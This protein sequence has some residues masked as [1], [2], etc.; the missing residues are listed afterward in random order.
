MLN[1]KGLSVL[2]VAALACSGPVE[3]T[4]QNDPPD[5]TRVTPHME[6]PI[7]DGQNVVYCST[8]QL[9]WNEM[10]DKVVGEEIRLEEPVALVGYLNSGVATRFGLSDNDYLAMAGTGGNETVREINRALKRKFGVA[11]PAME[12]RYG[13]SVVAYSYL[14]KDMEFERLFEEFKAQPVLYA[15]GNRPAEVQVFGI[16]DYADYEHSKLGAQAEILRYAGPDDFVVRLVGKNRDDALIVARTRPAQTLGE[17]IS[18]VE[19]RIDGVP[20]LDWNKGDVLAIPKL[21]VSFS[22]SYDEIAGLYLRNPGWEEFYVQEMVQ[23]IRFLLDEKGVS[24]ESSMKLAFMQKGPARTNR[25]M[26]CHTPFLV[27]IEHR[28]G[29][30]T[31][32]AVWVAN[33]EL[34]VPSG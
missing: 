1:N 2:A 10:V 11:I 28:G 17:T 3:T 31:C 12:E 8:M 5:H 25:V 16:Y 19:E 13:E 14:T 27:Y 32:F 9:A 21:R 7:A 6:V 26:V 22:H 29:A 23:D 24:M 33:E 30:H 20:P 15:G 34:M 4:P 18:R